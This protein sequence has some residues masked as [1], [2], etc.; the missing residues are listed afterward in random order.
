[1]PI[2]QRD[3]EKRSKAWAITMIV[4][5]VLIILGI[6]LIITNVVVSNPLEGEWYSEANGYYLEVE[7]ENEVTLQGTFN[8]TYMEIDLYYTIDKTEK[9]I[10]I[11]PNAESY[12]DA[13]EDSKGQMT[14]GE[15]DELL[16]DFT[17]S[18]NYNLEKDTLTLT[19]REYGEQYIFTR[20]EK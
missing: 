10:S 8:D 2:K 11:K 3:E 7:D 15:L 1:M 13:V 5:S 14:A 20:I 18:Y 9:I 6:V 4:S 12:A 16:T 17:V 19:E